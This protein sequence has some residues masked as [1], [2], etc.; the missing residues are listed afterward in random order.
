M[1]GRHTA[2]AVRRARSGAEDAKTIAWLA[3]LKHRAILPARRAWAY[4]AA[5]LLTI[6]REPR[7]T[8]CLCTTDSKCGHA[9]CTAPAVSVTVTGTG[10]A[11]AQLAAVHARLRDLAAADPFDGL[12][13]AAAGNWQPAPA[14]AAGRPDVDDLD[15][16]GVLPRLVDWATSAP[17]DEIRQAVNGA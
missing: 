8:A 14:P 3:A 2:R 13:N 17:A 1:S 16:T 12:P 11:S 10:E 6:D 15:D 5:L 9:C 4:V 7:C